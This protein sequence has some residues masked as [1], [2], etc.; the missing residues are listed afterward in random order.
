[1]H[2]PTKEAQTEW[3]ESQ[4]TEWFFHLVS[5][6]STNIKEQLQEQGFDTESSE[7]L[8]AARGNLWG[9]RTAFEQIA[10]CYQSKDLSE[11]EEGDEE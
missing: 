11:L 10:A 9:L 3:F 6:L 2:K 5:R 8:M 7:R 1:M 4:T